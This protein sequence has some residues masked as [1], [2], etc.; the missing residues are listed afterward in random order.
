MS[1]LCRLADCRLTTSCCET[2][3][4]ALQLPDSHLRELDLSVNALLDLKP[5]SVGLTSPNCRLESLNLSHMH[6][7]RSGPELLKAV[8]MGPHNQL[9]VLR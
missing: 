9:L 8:L 4:S 5:L 2:V 3:A 7:K 1:L 6:L